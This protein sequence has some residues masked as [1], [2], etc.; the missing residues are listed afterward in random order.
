MEQRLIPADDGIKL[1]VG[2]TGAGPDLVVLSGGPGCVHYLADDS[3]APRG[4]RAWYPEPRGVGRSDGA[5]HT[6]L[7]AVA[8]LEA[9]RRSIKVESWIVLGHSW[10]SD[11]AVFY[12]LQ[13]PRAVSG[14]IGIAGTGVQKDR[15]WSEVYHAERDK[16]PDIP[17][18]WD[19]EVHAALSSSY[20]EWIHEPQLL[21]RLADCPTSM[22]FIAAGLDI[23]PSWPLE[24]LAALLPR[25]SFKRIPDVPHDFW[26]T[27]PPVWVEVVTDACS[28]F[29]NWRSRPCRCPPRSIS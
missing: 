28:R 20:L 10:G 5:A 8:D 23:R 13:H 9:V 2:V 26:A 11:L 1:H 12:A 24:Q 3:I 15:T 25:G 21:R 7:E 22:T 29:I 4:L 16:E 17:I 19:S 14:V 6:M 27:D 18:A